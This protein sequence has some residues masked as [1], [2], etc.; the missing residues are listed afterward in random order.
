MKNIF[1]SSTTV[2]AIVLL[3]PV[4]AF[5]QVQELR[6]KPAEATQRLGAGESLSLQ[7]QIVAAGYK[8]GAVVASSKY[9]GTD[10]AGKYEVELVAQ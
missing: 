10:E 9:S 5:T 2:L 8:P 1:V 6:L 3:M 7:K 4:L